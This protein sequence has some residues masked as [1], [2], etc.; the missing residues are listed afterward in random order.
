MIAIMEHQMCVPS[1]FGLEG[2]IS[3]ELKRLDM[4]DVRAENGRVLFF[5]FGP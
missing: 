5:R 3:D 1:L 4:K 2:L